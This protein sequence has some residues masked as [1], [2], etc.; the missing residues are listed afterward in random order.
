MSSV[1]EV[2]FDICDSD[3]M[4]GEGVFSDLYADLIQEGSRGL[5]I[6]TG[7]VNN[8]GEGQGLVSACNEL[9]GVEGVV[10]L[11]GEELFAELVIEGDRVIIDGDRIIIEGDRIVI[12][13]ADVTI[14]T[15]GAEVLIEGADVVYEESNLGGIIERAVGYYCDNVDVGSLVKKIIRD[16]LI[17]FTSENIC[18]YEYKQIGSLSGAIGGF[19]DFVFDAGGVIEC[20]S[21]EEVVDAILRVAVNIVIGVDAGC[22]F[23]SNASKLVRLYFTYSLGISAGDL[24]RT[25]VDGGEGGDVYVLSGE[26][27]DVDTAGLLYHLLRLGFSQGEAYSI[28]SDVVVHWLEDFSF[29][30]K[31][32]AGTDVCCCNN[33]YFEDVYFRS[34]IN[35]DNVAMLLGGIISLLILF[36]EVLHPN[37]VWGEIDEEFFGRWFAPEGCC[38]VRCEREG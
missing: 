26:G 3:L 37:F 5:G 7:Y 27:F 35:P 16:V 28:A 1:K 33:R 10:V 24:I 25:L 36:P 38:S 31:V 11:E 6:I 4:Q 8:E 22:G 30:V 18:E 13:G 15:E 20:P 21:Q 17:R 34:T 19:S 9:S 23:L 2:P 14:E 12:E 29:L 32:M